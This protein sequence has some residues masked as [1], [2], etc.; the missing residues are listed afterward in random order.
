MVWEEDVSL[1]MFVCF[2]LVVD[3]QNVIEMEW[4]E[5][6]D[7][8]VCIQAPEIIIVIYDIVRSDM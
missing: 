3:K 4:I 5:L 6:W 7:C 8:A 1:S 2:L